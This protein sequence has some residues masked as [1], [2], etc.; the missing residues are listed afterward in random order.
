MSLRTAVN[1]TL[2]KAG[3]HNFLLVY[4][5]DL[6]KVYSCRRDHG[7]GE[8]CPA[9]MAKR[10]SSGPVDIAPELLDGFDR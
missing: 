9:V 7:K 3:V 5:D 8:M 1:R 6:E 4:K 10:L 2:C